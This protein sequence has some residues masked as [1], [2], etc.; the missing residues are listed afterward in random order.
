METQLQDSER[1]EKNSLDTTTAA[2]EM[3]NSSGICEG[4]VLPT[5]DEC[6]I[7]YDGECKIHNIFTVVC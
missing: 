3:R 7:F 6:K 4:I 2:V 5:D 1:K